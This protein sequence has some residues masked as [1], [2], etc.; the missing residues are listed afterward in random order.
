MVVAVAAPGR[1]AAW[2]VA[3][4]IATTVAVHVMDPGEHD[5]SWFERY[6]SWIG[7]LVRLNISRGPNQSSADQMF[8]ALRVPLAVVETLLASVSALALAT[9][10]AVIGLALGR[11]SR[12]SRS[13][14]AV[15]APIAS[16]LGWITVPLALA[17]ASLGTDVLPTVVEVPTPW[18]IQM[19]SPF[20][21]AGSWAHQMV[22]PLVVVGLAMLPA[23]WHGVGRLPD[24]MPGEPTSSALRA[25]ARPLV[26]LYPT[27]VAAMLVVEV[28]RSSF[29]ANQVLFDRTVRLW[30]DERASNVAT[31]VLMI[32]VGLALLMWGLESLARDGR[33]STPEPP[34]EPQPDRTDLPRRRL[35]SDRGARAGGWLLAALTLAVCYVSLW[36]E[37][38]PNDV[39]SSDAPAPPSGDHWLGVDSRG[40]DELVHLAAA[41][42]GSALVSVLAATAVTVV[43]VSWTAATGRL[44][45]RMRRGARAAADLVAVPAVAWLILAFDRSPATIGRLGLTLVIGALLVPIAVRTL[46]GRAWSDH[47]ATAATW[48]GTATAAVAA[49]S[50][51]TL[52][53]VQ[54]DEH[55]PT[56]GSLPALAAREVG[57]M[58]SPDLA[59]TTLPW[60]WYPPAIA[61]GALVLGVALLAV[62]VRR[63]D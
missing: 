8:T 63:P 1:R 2:L 20:G 21:V 48:L 26:R 25:V 24:A 60:L 4:T 9:S 56:L 53:L 62:R 41:T 3:L 27:C 15:V 28:A 42:L 7:G 18:D 38:G 39:V 57:F 49:E 6:V 16:L 52:L 5:R 10:L 33:P 32:G 50:L 61:T 11:R 23:V 30:F 17:A 51:V 12:R 44:P 36:F 22:F 54:L 59:A 34:A 55:A 43:G 19:S 13:S 47:R 45:E 35:R 37:A 58:P 46:A 40:R 31:G 29:G 14:V